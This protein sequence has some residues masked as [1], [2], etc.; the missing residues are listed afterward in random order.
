MKLSTF[1]VLLTAGF[2]AAI[3]LTVERAPDSSLQTRTDAGR[4]NKAKDDAAVLNI[5]DPHHCRQTE[6]ERV[7]K[8]KDDSAG[9]AIGGKDPNPPRMVSKLE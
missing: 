1:I 9:L 5:S 4:I 2:A 7:N 6:S 8:A 3:P